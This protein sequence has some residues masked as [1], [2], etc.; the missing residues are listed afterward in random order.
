MSPDPG[1]DARPGDE[2]RSA[3]RRSLEA[4][5]RMESVR[6][7]AA[8]TRITHDFG[9]AEDFAQDALL[10]AWEQWPE[11][12]LPAN[13]AGWLMTTAK[14]RAV[15]AYR[16][17]Q[18]G[19]R[20]LNT[21]AGNSQC[22]Q[23]DEA[24]TVLTALEDYLDD[25]ILRLILTAC[26]PVLSMEARVAL[27]LKCVAG[28]TTAEI[29][30]AYVVP[31]ATVAQRI[32]RAKKVLLREQVELRLPPL[33]RA[34][35]RLD[36]VLEVVF[37]N[38]NEGYSATAGTSWARPELCADARRLGRVVAARFPGECEAHGLA[39]LM[40]L[41]SSRLAARSDADG[42]PVALAEQDRRRWDRLLI[43]RGL[44]SLEIALALGQPVGPYTVQAAIA[45]CHARAAKTEDTDWPQITAWYDVLLRIW[46]SP[47]VELNQAV[48]IAEAGDP[49]R[50]L[51]IVDRLQS[52]G[53]LVSYP[54][55]AGVRGEVLARLG[56]HSQ[57]EDAFRVAAA[58]TTNPAERTLF[59]RRAER[60]AGPAD[61]R[62][63]H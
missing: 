19:D 30:R 21:L 37:S 5:W 42:R 16:R 57:A 43:R 41:Q 17:R 18:V 45:A 40:E 28:L 46:P 58:L 13:P 48:A 8:L 56:R 11:T 52:T 51:I 61:R 49:E 15:D 14:N 32:L 2:S 25:D 6:I 1:G 47:V 33:N 10:A 60:E 22:S 12:G 55:L 59:L 27:T 63:T 62:G 38:F 35:E 3:T 23:V 29:A 39:A 36:S 20:K 26:D 9:R 7:V 44:A 50:A 31:E 53:R 4:I 24:D 54:H 34:A